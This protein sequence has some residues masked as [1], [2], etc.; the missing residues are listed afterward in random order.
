VIA[1]INILDI[2][3]SHTKTL[4]G[5]E[6]EKI[7]VLDLTLFYAIPVLF[8]L[9]FFIFVP[10]LDENYISSVISL[11]AIFSAL[12]INAQIGLYSIFRSWE[13]HND[14][15]PTKNDKIRISRMS[16]RKRLVKDLN[17]NLSYLIVI[18]TI[19]LC[20]CFL[21]IIF[22][23]NRKIEDVVLITLAAHFVM[24]LLMAIKRVHV[25]FDGEY[26]YDT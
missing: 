14:T 2:V 9:L 21:F 13:T 6:N 8:G 16:S 7:L 1:K 26:R 22:D 11:Y 24:T 17:V 20:I 5:A 23:F 4:H 19:A 25:M 18:S 3:F 12:L 15:V 10:K